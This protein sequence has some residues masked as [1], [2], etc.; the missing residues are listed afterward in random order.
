[1][2]TW[3]PRP[4]ASPPVSEV[5]EGA[6]SWRRPVAAL[7]GP[8]GLLPRAQPGGAPM[9]ALTA[10]QRHIVAAVFRHMDCDAVGTMV[11]LEEQR[12]RLRAAGLRRSDDIETVTVLV[13][14]LLGRP[15]DAAA[16]TDVHRAH[17]CLRRFHWWP[18]GPEDLPLAALLVA[19]DTP[20]DEAVAG[21]GDLHRSL[22][23]NDEVPDDPAALVV[24]SDAGASEV[25]TR[26]KAL[27]TA[28]LL[29]NIPMQEADSAALLSLAL[30]ADDP[31][32]VFQEYLAVRCRIPGSPGGEVA[33]IAVAMAA[34]AVVL[35]RL[36]GRACQGFI[37]AL[38]IRAWMDHRRKQP[39][40]SRRHDRS[41]P[42][43]EKP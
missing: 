34:D 26:M 31:Q 38:V 8:D 4:P 14:L 10:E 33:T 13:R 17:Q 12:A 42:F 43:P 23:A 39:P 6:E 5:E 25:T 20:P 35:H 36:A 1:M 16:V 21:V 41:S 30:I 9:D 29:S 2:T 3:K 32:E 27:R 28:L 40:P 18:N 24:L 37:A 11:A 15:V 22:S 7:C 19:G